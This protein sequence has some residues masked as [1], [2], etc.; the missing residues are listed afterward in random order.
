M[1]FVE[2]M[3]EKVMHTVLSLEVGQDLPPGLSSPGTFWRGVGGR[4]GA[5]HDLVAGG[6]PLDGS[7]Q[8]SARLELTERSIT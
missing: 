3:E 1:V 7:S 2:F 8:G 4:R 5:W 6:P